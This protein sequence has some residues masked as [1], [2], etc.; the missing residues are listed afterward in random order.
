MPVEP[1]V[2]GVWN[3]SFREDFSIM[4]FSIRDSREQ[5][6]HQQ[7][8]SCVVEFRYV[9]FICTCIDSVDE[10][11]NSLFGVFFILIVSHWF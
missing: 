2:F 11:R 7:N 9:V 1:N 6:F 3:L 8:R 10:I 5:P 4:L